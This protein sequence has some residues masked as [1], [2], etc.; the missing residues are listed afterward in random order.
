MIPEIKPITTSETLPIRHK[1]MWPDKPFDYV[2]LPKDE[3]ARHFGLFV[4]G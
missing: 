2:K 3:M 4:N 1:V